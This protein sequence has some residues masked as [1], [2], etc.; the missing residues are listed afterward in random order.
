[1]V[2]WAAAS[3]SS[4]MSALS[5]APR[6]ISAQEA[7]PT[8]SATHAQRANMA[9][10]E[11]QRQLVRTLGQQQAVSFTFEGD[12]KLMWVCLPCVMCRGLTAHEVPANSLVQ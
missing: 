3:V 1:M 4:G 2:T 9:V 11:M 12:M 5:C 6:G 8:S 10:H 7:T